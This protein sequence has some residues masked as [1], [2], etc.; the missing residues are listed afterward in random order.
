M[1]IFKTKFTEDDIKLQELIKSFLSKPETL[2][3]VDPSPT[4]MSY[5]LSYEPLKYYIEIDSVGV[6]IS[7]HEF[8]KDI[9]LD[10]KKLDFIKE[11][12][13]EET[14]KRREA[15][16]ALIFKNKSLLLDTITKNVLNNGK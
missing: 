11:L 6:K 15:K 14:I 2:I 10:S 7:N 12:V 5:I 13:R 9:R 8:D 3:E 4:D 1:N 16:R